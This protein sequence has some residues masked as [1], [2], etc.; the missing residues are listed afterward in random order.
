LA[1]ALWIGNVKNVLPNLT[2]VEETLIARYRCRIILIKLRYSSNIIIGQRALKG[3]IISFSQNP[4]E[5]IK[6]IKTLPISLETLS[7][8]MA[9]FA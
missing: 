4:E 6:L 7:D 5:P 1:N 2:M 3:N 8:T 9:T